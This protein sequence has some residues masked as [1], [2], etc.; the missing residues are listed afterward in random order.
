MSNELLTALDSLRAKRTR[1]NAA[2]AA[3]EAAL[4][5]EPV[6]STNPGRYGKTPAAVIE[7][8]RSNPG[9]HSTG[10]ITDGITALGINGDR[11][12]RFTN[13]FGGLRRLAEKG[14]VVKVGKLWRY[15]E[16]AAPSSESG[17]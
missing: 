11:R 9:L 10:A 8:L 5:E 3:L 15:P 1:I 6:P 13:V 17:A 7:W 2:I 14:R 4:G 16:S 12:L